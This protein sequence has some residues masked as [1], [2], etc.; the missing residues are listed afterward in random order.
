MARDD[1]DDSFV[2]EYDSSVV[3]VDGSTADV[4]VDISSIY[5]DDMLEKFIDDKGTNRWRCKW[6]TYDF[7][8][9]NATKALHHVNKVGGKDIKPCK[10]KIDAERAKI[11]K[12]LLKQSEQKRRKRIETAIAID[13]SID[14]VAQY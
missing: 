3:V 12:Q 13:R 8:G 2:L 11:Y 14:R 10:A 6:C 7:A 5:E 9:W 4:V 1:D